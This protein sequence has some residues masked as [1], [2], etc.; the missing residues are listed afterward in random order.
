MQGIY[1]QYYT[2]ENSGRLNNNDVYTGKNDFN[3]N[4]FNIDLTFSWEFAPGSNLSMV[5]KNAITTEDSEILRSYT[6]NF[7]ETMDAPQL[8]SFS[9][10]ILYYLDYQNLKKQVYENT[11]P[12]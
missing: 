8:N 9:L 6:R 10:R 11:K 12:G 4:S 3:F 1:N 2:L 5:W 7:S